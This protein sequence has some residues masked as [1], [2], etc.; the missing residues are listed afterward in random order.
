M[1]L[2][3]ALEA[4]QCQWGELQAPLSWDQMLIWD[5]GLLEGQSGKQGLLK[6][7]AYV[8]GGSVSKDFKGKSGS[9]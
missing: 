9:V 5:A 1:T 8:A 3:L 6:N 4:A 2:A 7:E